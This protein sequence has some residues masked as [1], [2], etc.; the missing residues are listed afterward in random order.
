MIPR[1]RVLTAVMHETPS[2]T[3]ADLRAEPL[4]LKRLFEHFGPDDQG[5][6]RAVFRA[7]SR[8]QTEAGE[9]RVLAVRKKL[10]EKD[11]AH[12]KFHINFYN[13]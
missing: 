2:R 3:P 10:F 7:D 1:E 4:T 5:R 12:S 13:C 6:G 8:M 9:E 11:A